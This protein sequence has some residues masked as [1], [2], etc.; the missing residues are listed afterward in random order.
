MIVSLRNEYVQNLFFYRLVFHFHKFLSIIIFCFLSWETATVQHQR[1]DKGAGNAP[2]ERERWVS[3]VYDEV[4]GFILTWLMFQIFRSGEG[5]E[6]KQGINIKSNSRLYKKAKSRSRSKSFVRREMQK[7][8]ISKQKVTSKI[9][10][11]E[12]FSLIY[13]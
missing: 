2:A 3:Q 9:K 8:R 5:C 1:P 4:W 12:N 11:M 13:N 7:T 6:T 10:S